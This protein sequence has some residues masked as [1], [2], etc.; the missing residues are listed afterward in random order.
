MRS[1][2]FLIEWRQQDPRGL[3][4]AFVRLPQ[5]QEVPVQRRPPEKIQVAGKGVSLEEARAAA[6]GEGAERYSLSTITI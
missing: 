1:N 2:G 6:R 3:V 5:N 4:T